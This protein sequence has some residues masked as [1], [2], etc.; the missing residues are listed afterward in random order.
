MVALK[1]FSDAGVGLMAGKVADTEDHVNMAAAMALM[2]ML[3]FAG[4]PVA[5][6]DPRHHRIGRYVI[7]DDGGSVEPT[8]CGSTRW[9]ATKRRGG[10]LR[11]LRLQD[12]DRK[13]MA[14]IDAR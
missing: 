7:V 14:M 10:P 8:T 3:K 6:T 5:A 4:F 13:L 1:A 9:S 12:G 11:N 2:P